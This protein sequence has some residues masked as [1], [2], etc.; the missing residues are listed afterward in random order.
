MPHPVGRETNR[1]G[2]LQAVDWQEAACS[3]AV[4]FIDRVRASVHSLLFPLK[5]SSSSPL[6][7]THV[8]SLK[9]EEK[10]L[11]GK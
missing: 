6:S 4:L 10:K 3:P 9:R 7:S 1:D 11:A 8:D 5:F 2:G